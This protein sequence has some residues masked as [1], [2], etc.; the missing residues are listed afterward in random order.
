MTHP[1]PLAS[2]RIISF[3]RGFAV[4]GIV[5]A[6]PDSFH[7]G[8]RR[9]EAALIRDTALAMFAAGAAIVDIGG[10]STR[11][12]A[13]YVGTD[14][15]LARVIPAIEAIRA[16]SDLPISVDTR[17]TAVAEA[18][19]DAGA[20][21]I[22]DITALADPRMAELAAARKAPVILMHMQGSPETMQDEPHY[23]DCLSEVRAFLACAAERAEAAGVSRDC[24]ILDPGIGFGKRARDNLDL[25][26]G[27]ESL[28]GLG[29]PVL[30]G[31]SR[32]RIIGEITG[33]PIALRLA[34][35]LGAAC[36]AWMRGA[37]IFRVHDVAETFDALLSLSS[38]YN[39]KLPTGGE[40]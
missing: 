11:P 26:S 23:E 17:K 2:G 15:E 3:A 4:M 40:G 29:Y 35:S 16:C 14:E 8:S 31:I 33:K 28:V 19:L 34:G 36:A 20:D 24:I 13:A 7:E 39:G 37:S 32:K 6:T 38:C 27:L 30:A 9:T 25:L 18:A 1:I 5:N 12:G 10:E 22:N 21:I